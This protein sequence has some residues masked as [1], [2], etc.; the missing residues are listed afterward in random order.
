MPQMGAGNKEIFYGDF[1]GLHVKM[2]QGLQMQVLN[3]RFADQYAVGIVA[4]IECD[5]AI[6]ESQKVAAF[7]GA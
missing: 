3:E 5:S 4:V 7:V 1:S 2:T 6:V